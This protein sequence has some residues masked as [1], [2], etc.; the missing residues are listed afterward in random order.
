VAGRVLT[1][2]QI[3]PPIVGGVTTTSKRRARVNG[4][5]DRLRWIVQHV[6][7]LRCF[8]QFQILFRSPVRDMGC[9]C[10]G[11]QPPRFLASSTTPLTAA[12]RRNQCLLVPR[13]HA[14]TP[15]QRTKQI[16][17]LRQSLVSQCWSSLAPWSYPVSSCQR[18][19][20]F[21]GGCDYA[22][23]LDHRVRSSCWGTAG[24]CAS[25]PAGAPGMVRAG[26]STTVPG[27]EVIASPVTTICPIMKGCGVQV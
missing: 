22:P 9:V 14:W 10:T 4:P 2:P 21:L 12:K 6:T 15:A 18:D 8:W 7:L 3:Q 13:M 11:C 20:D 27:A 26:E 23:M 19:N 5:E 24:K 25:W 1:A 17:R 16:A